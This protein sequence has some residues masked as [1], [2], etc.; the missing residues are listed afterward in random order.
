[1]NVE[2]K[3]ETNKEYD[4]LTVFFLAFSKVK[5]TSA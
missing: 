1:M 4:I 2:K 5:Q 3:T